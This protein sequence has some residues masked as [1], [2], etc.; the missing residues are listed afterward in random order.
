M[1]VSEV[2][3]WKD[4]ANNDVRSQYIIMGLVKGVSLHAKW[5]EMTL[6]QRLSCI[7]SISTKMQHLVE[8]NFPAYGSIY[9]ADAPVEGTKKIWLND[10]YCIGPSC[11]PRY[12]DCQVDD[13]KF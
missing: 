12:W 11:A 10:H 13:S 1:P 4:D 7:T 8:M 9:F 6:A 3:D 2:L 5:P